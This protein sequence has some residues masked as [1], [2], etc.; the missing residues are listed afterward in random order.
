MRR[1]ARTFPMRLLVSVCWQNCNRAP[2]AFLRK[3]CLPWPDGLMLPVAISCSL[4]A[5]A[6]FWSKHSEQGGRA[7]RFTQGIFT[8]SLI[9]SPCQWP[10]SNGSPS[11]RGKQATWATQGS[12]DLAPSE[13]APHPLHPRP[14]GTFTRKDG[15]PNTSYSCPEGDDGRK[16]IHVVVPCA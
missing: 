4:T 2:S 1:C 6:A 16:M 7:K 12:L 5:I 11:F 8:C 13:L 15:E 3:P 14:Y 10:L 9:L